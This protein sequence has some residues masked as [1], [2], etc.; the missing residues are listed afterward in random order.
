M[1]IAGL[2]VIALAVFW[3]KFAA[4]ATW[5]DLGIVPAKFSSDVRLGLLAFLA[6]TVP[7]YAVMF[8]A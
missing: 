4:R 5:A 7:V 3:L 8:A 1:A 2:A 6:V